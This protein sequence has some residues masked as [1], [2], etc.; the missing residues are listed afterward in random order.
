MVWAFFVGTLA[1]AYNNNSETATNNPNV[2][3]VG[4]SFTPGNAGSQSSGLPNAYL[5]YVFYDETGT[6]AI[7]SGKIFVTS[8]AHTAW[9]RLHFDYE[10][11]ANGI[12]QI[13]TANETDRQNVW[14]D[15]LKVD[16]TPQLIVQENHYYPFGMGLSGIEKVGKP[17]HKYLYNGKEKQEAFG[18]NWLSYGQREYDPAIGRFNRVD[19]FAEKYYGFSSYQYGANDPI[20]HID[21]NGDSLWI[22]FKTGFLGLGKR[23]KVLYKDGVLQ[24]ADGTRYEGKGIKVKNGVVKIQNGFLKK[25]VNALG[26]IRGTQDG[27]IMVSELQGSNNTF[28]IF[29]ASNNKGVNEFSSD[30]TIRAH[31]N[32]IRTDPQATVQLA[33]LTRLGTNL[34]GGAG[35]KVYWEPSGKKMFTTSGAQK[36]T[37]M[38]LAHEMFHGLD[39]N[40]GL[41]DT[42]RHLGVARREWQ[43]VYR[44]N[45][46]RSQ[47]NLPLR[48]HYIKRKDVNGNMTPAGPRML[49]PTNQPLL[50]TWYIR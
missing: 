49:T 47:L 22:S 27:G 36:N 8:V 38:I 48:T 3:Q 24:N 35:G 31:A 23:K 30:N 29:H 9:E 10:I 34:S 50:P 41:L 40:R 32:Q 26:E 2:L 46:V 39:A 28:T 25:V 45:L 20:K 42:R 4:V 44:T 14:F 21:V 18:L 16:F 6:R 19:R 13:Y 11:P 1:Q 7:Q 12:L 37:S 15:D 43:A 5:R 33:T 17:N